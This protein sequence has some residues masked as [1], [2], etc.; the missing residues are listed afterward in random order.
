MIH[1]YAITS[2]PTSLSSITDHIIEFDDSSIQS[3]LEQADFSFIYFYSD[4]CKYCRKFEP[5]FENL[6][7]LYNQVKQKDTKKRRG[8]KDNN[9]NNNN[10]GLYF[11]ILKTNARQN[12]RLS[13]LFKISQYPTLKLLN[14]KTKEIITYD[15]KNNR[16]LQSIINYLRQNL[17]IEPQFENFKTKVKYYQ[18]PSIDSSKQ[19]LNCF[20]NENETNAHDKLVFFITS[21][22]PDWI[23]YQYPAHFVHQLA[24]DYQD[25]TIIV[26]DVEK[27]ND[28]VVLSKYEINSFPSVMYLKNNGDYKKY[29]F[30]S[31]S[32]HELDYH[33]IEEFI[34]SIDQDDAIWEK[35]KKSPVDTET[36]S[37]Q[38]HEVD[39][40][41]E[42]DDLTFEH[43]EL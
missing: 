27:L 16:D 39:N 21:Y 42:E 9:N 17:K 2:S 30:S 33:Q 6:S 8:K 29:Q 18:S 10:G 4:V 15:N 20:G 38:Q 14:Y 24:L 28:Y 7:V 22:L 1:I 12:N 11:Q 37:Q 5:T 41:D 40:D 36:I 34:E 26:V 35:V 31:Q 43:I 3:T 13:Q 19:D 23:D 25:L 32:K